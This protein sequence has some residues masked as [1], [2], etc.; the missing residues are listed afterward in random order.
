MT[1]FIFVRNP[2]PRLVSVYFEKILGNPLG[3]WDGVNQEIIASQ[4]NGRNGLTPKRSE[5]LQYV[6]EDLASNMVEANIHWR[7]QSLACPICTGSFKIIG[8]L[9]EMWQDTL[10]IMHRNNLWNLMDGSLHENT[11]GNSNS[12]QRD[13][14]FWKGIDCAL[15]K[16]LYVAYEYDFIAF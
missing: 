2:W 10:Y 1:S 8:K 7:P 13:Y 12:S 9:E 15:I 14:L 5:F 16:D 6:L 3:A 11:S 4:R